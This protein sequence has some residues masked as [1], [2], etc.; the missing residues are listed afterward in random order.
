MFWRAVTLTVFCFFLLLCSILLIV[1]SSIGNSWSYFLSIIG[2]PSNLVAEPARS[3]YG[4]ESWDGEIGN[5]GGGNGRKTHQHGGIAC[6]TT[7]DEGGHG[8]NSPAIAEFSDSWLDSS[9]RCRIKNARIVNYHILDLNGSDLYHKRHSYLL[10][11]PERRKTPFDLIHS[12]VWGPAP[13]TDLHGFR[14]FLVFLDD[15]SRF[16]WIYLLKHKPGVTLKIKKYVQMIE[17]QFEKWI[18]IIRIDNAKDLINHDLQ[19]FNAN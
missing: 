5:S 8:S 6:W 13:S 16:S 17:R 4:Q 14:W 7:A 19:K 3:A 11:N 12:N 9:A 15:C 10:E 1:P 2:G 18:K